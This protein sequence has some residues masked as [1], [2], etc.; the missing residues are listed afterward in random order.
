[1]GVHVVRLVLQNAQAEKKDTGRRRN[2]GTQPRGYCTYV[3]RDL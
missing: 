3:Q 1:V 2:A